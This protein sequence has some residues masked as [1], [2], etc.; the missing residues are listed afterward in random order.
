[1]GQNIGANNRERVR[2]VIV[3]GYTL[4]VSLAAFL[5]VVVLSLGR[6]ILG[7]FIPGEPEAIE[8]GYLRLVM[9]IGPAVLNAMHN[10]NRSAL[11]AYGYTFLQMVT[12]LVTICLFS[13]LWME[14]IYGTLIAKT[15]FNF[16]LCYPVTWVISA[17]A[18]LTIVVIL[19]K[20]YMNGKE[21]SI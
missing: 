15:P 12:N 8:F 5:S 17:A 11:I 3:R 19:T 14:L 13:V 9:I 6:L 4:N 21:F 20:K 7:L 1:M 16:L 18:A 10:V 2:S